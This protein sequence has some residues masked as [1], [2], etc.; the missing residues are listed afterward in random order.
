MSHKAA[1]RDRKLLRQPITIPR[2]TQSP[3]GSK[4]VGIDIKCLN[5][6]NWFPSPIFF[7][8]SKS[9]DTSYMEGNLAQCH[10]CG[11]MTN[12][13]KENMRAKFEGGSGGFVG[14]DA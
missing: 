1:K 9:L 13:N 10:H 6:Q 5:C 14:N 2:E 7:G 8:D 4:I 3:T 12:C 11:K